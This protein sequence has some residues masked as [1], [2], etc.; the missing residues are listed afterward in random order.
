[1]LKRAR[2]LARSGQHD[3]HATIATAL[4]A[5]GDF[6]DVHHCLTERTISSQL[7]RLCVMAQAAAQV[8]RRPLATVLAE[9][10]AAHRR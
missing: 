9:M 5:A 7:D 8:S 2:D 6:A 10:R 1:L 3:N 4:Q